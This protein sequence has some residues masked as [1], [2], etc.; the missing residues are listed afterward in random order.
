M[1]NNRGEVMK[2]EKMI[3]DVLKI[4]TN[5]EDMSPEFQ[6]E[7]LRRHPKSKRRLMN[8]MKRNDVDA[9]ESVV[10]KVDVD[11]EKRN[12]EKLKKEL[13]AGKFSVHYNNS[14]T[15]SDMYD[16]MMMECDPGDVIVSDKLNAVLM[17]FE[18]WPTV[19]FSKDKPEEIHIFKD[20]VDFDK[21][22]GGAYKRPRIVAYEE[23]K[24]M[25]QRDKS[26]EQ[27]GEF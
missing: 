17:M 26:G 27:I 9:I 4:S 24:K 2:D 3:S 14:D 8:R 21:L 12:G 5:W 18:A 15:G 16:W 20:D 19:A 1:Y 25:Q 6:H 22:E 11:D 23:W 7:Y 13:D 10:R